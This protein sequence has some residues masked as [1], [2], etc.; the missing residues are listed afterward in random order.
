[1]HAAVNIADM[2]AAIAD[3]TVPG[4]FS[5]DRTRFE[6]P[7]LTY[8]G[9]RAPHEWKIIVTLLA[10][11]AGAPAAGANSVTIIFHSWGARA[12]AYVSVG[13][14]KRVRSALKAPGTVPS[15]IAARMSAMFTAACII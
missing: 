10:P 4:A 8:A 14:S 6:F 13:N 3:G 2:R 12:P 7:T 9:A 11:A 5:A 1:M 15:A